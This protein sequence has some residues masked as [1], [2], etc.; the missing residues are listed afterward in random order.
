MAED[1]KTKHQRIVEFLEVAETDPALLSHFRKG[2]S[3]VAGHILTQ[4][5]LDTWDEMK[6]TASDVKAR[7]NLA[8]QVREWRGDRPP[9]STIFL[10][11]EILAISLEGA[12]ANDPIAVVCEELADGVIMKALHDFPTRATKILT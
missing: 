9:D 7:G 4:T 11:Y 8:E 5:N 1:W 2:L 10:A 3:F 6:R 12:A